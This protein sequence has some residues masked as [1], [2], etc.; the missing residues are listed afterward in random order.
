MEASEECDVSTPMVR[1]MAD[2]PVSSRPKKT[3]LLVKTKTT[4]TFERMD[5]GF[6]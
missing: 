6:W 1:P 4:E 5:T 2:Q 3:R